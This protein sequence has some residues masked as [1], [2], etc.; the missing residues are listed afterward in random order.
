MIPMATSERRVRRSATR[1]P[2]TSV[3]AKMAPKT[4][5]ERSIIF[6]SGVR[7][8]ERSVARA[9]AA[10]CSGI[11]GSRLSSRVVLRCF[12]AVEEGFLFRNGAGLVFAAVKTQG[13]AV[14]PAEARTGDQAETQRAQQPGPNVLSHRRHRAVGHP[15]RGNDQINGAEPGVEV[16]RL[17]LRRRRAPSQEGRGLLVVLV[18]IDLMGL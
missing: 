18:Q 6:T 16:G 11:Q 15:A 13:R 5:V 17:K 14:R 4:R 7:I 8:S 2:T 1:L 12:T 10:A 9:V 3:E